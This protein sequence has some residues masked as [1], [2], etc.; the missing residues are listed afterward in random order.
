VQDELRFVTMWVLH[1]NG[2]REIFYGGT[3][4]VEITLLA[5][6]GSG[7]CQGWFG[8]EPEWDREGASD[9]ANDLFEASWIMRHE[10]SDRDRSLHLELFYNYYI[11]QVRLSTSGKAGFWSSIQVCMYSRSEI[12]AGVVVS[13][14]GAV[15]TGI[16]TMYVCVMVCQYT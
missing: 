11:L 7:V 10:P 2:Y 6:R 13:K 16:C 15:L 5:S 3:G 9:V 8:L 14:I 1:R 12:S 4:S